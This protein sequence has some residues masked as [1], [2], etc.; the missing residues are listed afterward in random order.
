MAVTVEVKK[1][2]CVGNPAIASSYQDRKYG[3]GMR[4]CNAN[5]KGDMVTCSVC[6]KEHKK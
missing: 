6:G 1:C 3:K 5:F 2:G 4:L